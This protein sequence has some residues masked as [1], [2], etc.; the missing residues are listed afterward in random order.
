MASG[1]GIEHALIGFIMHE[2]AGQV[3]FSRVSM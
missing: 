1:Y 3:L 2:E